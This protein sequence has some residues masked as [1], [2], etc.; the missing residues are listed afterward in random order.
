VLELKVGDFDAAFVGQ[1]NL[2]VNAIDE[3]VA[4]PDD[5]PTIGIILCA[6]RDE[7]VT[8]LTLHG[9]QA[10]IAVATYRLGEGTTGR[11]S[12]PA[13]ISARTREELEEIKAVEEDLR[14]FATR[15]VRELAAARERPDD[16]PE[17]T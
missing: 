1:I 13:G 11:D 3:R 4:H 15:K 8:R 5:K 10:P 16:E 6:S 17:T 12:F 7:T 14:R 2:Y 9:I